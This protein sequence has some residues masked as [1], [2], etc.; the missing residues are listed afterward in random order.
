[1]HLLDDGQHPRFVRIVAVRADAEVHLLRER[2]SFVRRSQFEDPVCMSF[3]I[4]QSSLFTTIGNSYSR[5][6]WSERYGVP[7]FS[8]NVEMRTDTLSAEAKKKRRTG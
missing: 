7:G 1:M 5:I 2:I 3:T 6:R 8:Y 4:L